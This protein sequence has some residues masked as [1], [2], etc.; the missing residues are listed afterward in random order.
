MT[1]EGEKIRRLLWK[2]PGIGAEIA[3]VL[4]GRLREASRSPTD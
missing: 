2:E 4:A 1:I 3:R